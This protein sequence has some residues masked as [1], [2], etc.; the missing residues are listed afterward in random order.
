MA[1]SDVALYAGNDAGTDRFAD[2]F[3]EVARSDELQALVHII[4]AHLALRD[5]NWDGAMAELNRVSGTG[6]AWALEVRGL[7]AALPFIDVDDGTVAEIQEQ[8]E[9]WDPAAAPVAADFPLLLH[10]GLHA[11]LRHYL[12]ALLAARLGDLDTAGH[13]A[14]ALED[15]TVPDDA[16]AVVASLVAGSH[17][18]IALARGDH[19]TALALLE[20]RRPPVWFQHAVASPFYSQAFERYMRGEALLALGRVDEARGWF[21]SLVE[22]TPFELIYRNATNIECHGNT[23]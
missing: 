12:L 5:G 21:Q 19:A 23:E 15:E 20:A 13:H 11:H 16:A 3:L 1:F 8:I 18:R 7:F 17:A 14:A 22:R 2:A 10:N 9:T 6:T 4:R